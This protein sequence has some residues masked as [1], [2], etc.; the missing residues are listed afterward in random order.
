MGTLMAHI[1]EF[2]IN[3]YTILLAE[4]SPTQA[5]KLKCT[6]EKSGYTV[7]V[8]KNG[9]EALKLVV[10]NKPSLVISDIIMPEMSGYELCKEIKSND[11]T[12]NIPV[13]LLTSLA[14]SEDVLEG[15]SCGADN[16]LTKPYSEDYLLAHIEQI[17]L[18]RVIYKNER[19]KIGF[20]ILFNGK[21]RF[22]TSDQQQMLSLLLSTYEAAVFK[23]NEL[24]NAQEKLELLN[25]H[26]EELVEARTAELSAEIDIRKQAE[27]SIIK[28]NRIYSV[29]SNINQAIVRIHDKTQLLKDVCLI[30]IDEGKFVR[31]WIGI[32]NTTTRQIEK[33]ESAGLT[34]DYFDNISN[35]LPKI[36][37]ISD[38]IEAGKHFIS[39]DINSDNRLDI[40]WKQNSSD[41]G[42]KSFGVFPLIVLKKVIGAFGIFSNEID[43]FDQSEIN[44]L[45]EMATD[46]SFALEF[47]QKES[48]RKLADIALVEAKN[49]AE[50]ANKLKDAFIANIS[51][52][53][54]TPLNGLLGMTNLIK[55]IFNSQCSKE[56]EMLFD[57]I[58]YS[59]KRIIRTVDSILNY[60]RLQVGEFITIH[61]KFCLSSVCNTLI[62]EFSTAAKF[63]S[64]ELTFQNN[65]GE[66]Y[67]FADEYS[68]TMAISNL[69]DNAIK[70]TESGFVNLI[71][72]NANN[73]IILDVIDSGI[74]IDD[75]YLD[76]I[77]EPF[78]Q[79]QMGYGRAYEGIGL[80]LAIV[81]KILNLNHASIT[82]KSKKGKGSIFSINFG[83]QNQS[84]NV[85]VENKETNTIPRVPEDANNMSI[86]IVEDDL[87]NQTT[88]KRFIGNRYNT[89]CT[90]SSDKVIEIL[91]KNKIDLILMDISIKGGKNGLELTKELKASKDFLHIPVIAVTAHAFE[92]DKQNALEAGCDN[93]LAKP[94][95]KESLLEIIGTF[96]S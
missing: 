94:F 7:I 2:K 80:G 18:N 90:D 8:A 32:Y 72:S 46:I 54:R 81:I 26:L 39:N 38:V 61:K 19:V 67:T 55:D 22:I 25:E 5:E 51:H 57:G 45:D 66:V 79:E 41:L 50:S 17:L 11:S 74:G 60:S 53:I 68:I 34:N 12:T 47:I 95:T 28:L 71:L 40:I 87:L 88:I 4:D 6:L 70:Y 20:E 43:F 56:D 36:S 62:S 86:L 42:I 69:V 52:E 64:L 33:F 75:E 82:V 59:S 58:D 13:I 92:S 96:L 84:V 23:N 27:L 10:E 44:L 77:F 65:C 76:L 78:R 24:V 16:Y 30:A 29:L 91:H 85:E 14:S 15:I 9:K 1:K 31:I 73:D 63:K 3:S 48:E 49:S 83:N 21:K 89:L 37:F 35:N 93:Y